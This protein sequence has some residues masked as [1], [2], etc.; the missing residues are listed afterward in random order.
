MRKMILFNAPAKSGKDVVIK[1][2]QEEGI[3]LQYAE[4]KDKLHDLVQEIFNVDFERYWEIYDDRSLK[5]VPL[6][7]FHIHMHFDDYYRFEEVL[8][9]ALVDE[10]VD[11]CPRLVGNTS[12]SLCETNLSIREAMIYVSEVLIKPRFG[13]DYFGKSRMLRMLTDGYGGGI[14]V[15]GSA[16]FV[17]ELAPLIG[18]LGQPNILLIRIHREGYTFEGDS[19]S[20]IPDGVIV[21]TVDVENN[22]TEQEYFDKVEKIVRGFLDE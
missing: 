14:Y 21:N 11:D 8:G 20:Y 22:R 18:E 15:D 7:D 9:H 10:W 3:P 16:A 4:C 6:Q 19:R 1:Y 13:E 12:G 2:L 17:E 5:E